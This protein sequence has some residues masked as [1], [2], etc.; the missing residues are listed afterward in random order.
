MRDLHIV[1]EAGESVCVSAHGEVGFKLFNLAIWRRQC[2]SA[3]VL[4]VAG[5]S[6]CQALESGCS[7][8][9]ICP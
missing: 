5:K 4:R 3:L 1:A 9:H 6:P 8:T 2:I 7:S